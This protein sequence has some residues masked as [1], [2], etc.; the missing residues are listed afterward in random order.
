[1]LFSSNE[2]NYLAKQDLSEG[3][4]N[5]SSH[6]K[7]QRSSNCS[8]KTKNLETTLTDNKNLVEKIK[9]KNFCVI[10]DDKLPFESQ[11]IKSF[12]KPCCGKKICRHSYDKLSSYGYSQWKEQHQIAMN[13]A[14]TAAAT[15]NVDN[16]ELS[17]R[18]LVLLLVVVKGGFCSTAQEYW[19]SSIGEF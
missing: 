12:K 16:D 7:K 8:F 13:V 19:S 4:S 9:F 11:V 6:F 5:D 1:M 18:I 15:Q 14:A 2:V 3:L 17:K 10:I